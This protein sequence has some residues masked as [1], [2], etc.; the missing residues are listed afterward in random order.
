M[1]FVTDSFEGL[2]FYYCSDELTNVI[3]W[4]GKW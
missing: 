1:E 3:G 4:F 2:L